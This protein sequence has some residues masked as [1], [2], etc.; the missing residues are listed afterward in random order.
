MKTLKFENLIDT[1][2]GKTVEIE[3]AD[4]FDENAGSYARAGKRG[5]EFG[6]RFHKIAEQQRKEELK[7]QIRL[8]MVKNLNEVGE[9]GKAA[10]EKLFKEFGNHD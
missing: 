7:N 8:R 3:V 6:A 9:L 1:N 10:G 2:T 5:G 4:D